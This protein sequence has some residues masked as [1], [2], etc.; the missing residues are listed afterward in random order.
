MLPGPRAQICFALLALLSPAL[1]AAADDPASQPGSEKPFIGL[2]LPLNAPEFAPAAEAVRLGCQAAL[3][4]SDNRQPLQ[5]VR[6]DAKAESVLAEYDAAVQRGAAVIVGPLTR[7]GVTALASAGRIS[8]TTLTLNVADGDMPLPPRLYTFGLSVEPEARLVARIAFA[9]G[10]RDAVVVQAATFLARR[11]SRAFADEWFALGGR[12]G[13]VREFAP[14]T[15]LVELRQ[16]L[17]DSEAHMVFLSAD[18]EQARRVRPYLSNKMSVFA[19][20]Q[21]NDGKTGPLVNSDLNGIRFVDMPWI[22][23]PDHAAVMIY[24]RLEGFS[25]ELQRLYALGIDSCR[26]AADLLAGHQR[27]NLDGVTG[28]ILLRGGNAL[29]REPVQAVFRDGVGVSVEDQR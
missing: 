16:H 15:S 1:C 27:I 7:S 10:L 24:P 19:T 25:T 18:A 20:S 29:Q 22:V 3:R 5:V 13:D 2:L 11:V 9:R 26:I 4:F 21:V 28:R 6:T 17:A 14:Q 23:Q 8:V 12:I